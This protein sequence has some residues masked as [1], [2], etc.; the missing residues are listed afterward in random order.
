MSISI[1]KASQ[2]SFYQYKQ[3]GQYIKFHHQKIYIMNY[4]SLLTKTNDSYDTN[5][6]YKLG[7]KSFWTVSATLSLI[8]F[9]WFT[10]GSDRNNEKLKKSMVRSN[11]SLFAGLLFKI[12]KNVFFISSGGLLFRY[13][14]LVV[15][16]L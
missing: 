9:T 14:C 6:I 5:C 1:L 7:F 3:Y 12:T 16:V 4:K 8:R 13:F 11:Y 2:Y 10:S 15:S